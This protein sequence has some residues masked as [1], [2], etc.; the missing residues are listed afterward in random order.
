MHWC[1]GYH[2]SICGVA[3]LL[4]NEAS[5]IEYGTCIRYL[6]DDQ[7]ND[8]IQSEKMHHRFMRS[9]VCI[10]AGENRVGLA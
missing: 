9:F 4:E 2:C 6:T 10:H 8:K 7:W 3:D 1:S 5:A